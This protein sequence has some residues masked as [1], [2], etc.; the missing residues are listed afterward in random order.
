MALEALVRL[1]RKVF[2]VTS[3][4]GS[5]HFFGQTEYLQ[6]PGYGIESPSTLSSSIPPVF[7][8]TSISFR[9]TGRLVVTLTR[10]TAYSSIAIVL[11]NQCIF[12][13]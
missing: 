4:E 1:H 9:W 5:D 13:L 3:R 10:H 6:I 11:S 2:H 7:G 8:I 12:S